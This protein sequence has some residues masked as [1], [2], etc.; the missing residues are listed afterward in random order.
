MHNHKAVAGFYAHAAQRRS[1]S[2]PF[3]TASWDSLSSQARQQAY[4][5]VM[6]LGISADWCMNAQLQ[7]VFIC[8]LQL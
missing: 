5:T 3:W 8:V 1:T 6:H 4:S 2:S 7:Q